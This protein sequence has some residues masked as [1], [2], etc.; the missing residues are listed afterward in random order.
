M[1][2]RVSP[3]VPFRELK[4]DRN[5]GIFPDYRLVAACLPRPRVTEFVEPY[6]AKVRFS[7][8]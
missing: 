2:R 6:V 3:E 7:V 4:G 1:F 5:P 8:F